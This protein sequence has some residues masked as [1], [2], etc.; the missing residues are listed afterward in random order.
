MLRSSIPGWPRTKVA[1]LEVRDQYVIDMRPVPEMAGSYCYSHRVMYID[2]EIH[3]VSGVDMYDKNGLLWKYWYK[4]AN[5][6]PVGSHGGA[7]MGGW[8]QWSHAYDLQN[9]HC[10]INW[11][12]RGS[13]NQ[14]V[15]VQ[16]RNPALYALPSGL[17]QIMR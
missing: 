3:Y 5:Y 14:D 10:S 13:I 12:S 6:K 16:F 9:D 2:K 7:F 15:P 4:G 1:P 17:S 8:N 11:N